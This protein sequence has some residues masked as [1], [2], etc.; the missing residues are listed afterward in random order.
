MGIEE[1]A[2]NATTAPVAENQEESE[3]PEAEESDIEKPETEKPETE[4]PETEKP[5]S[6]TWVHRKN[7]QS[8]NTRIGYDAMARNPTFA[9]AEQ[10]GG[11]WEVKQLTDHFHP[12]VAL[13]ATT[14]MEG[15]GIE[16][17]G[18]PLQDFTLSRF[19][20][21]FVFRNPKLISTKKA[22]GPAQ[23]R[24]L[25]KRNIYKPQGV[26]AMAVDG[27]EFLKQPKSSIPVDELYLYQYFQRR[28]SKK[29]IAKAAEEEEIDSDLESVVSEDFEKYLAENTDL[30]FASVVKK[31]KSKAEKIKKKRGN[32]E[33][34]DD[35]DNDSETDLDAAE[36][37]SADDYD[38]DKDFQEA[39][40]DFDEMLN[41]KSIPDLAAGGDVEDM[42]DE[43]DEMDGDDDEDDDD[44]DDEGSDDDDDDEFSDEENDED[45]LGFREEDVDFSDDEEKEEKEGKGG[46]GGK[47]V[48]KTA[49]KSK[50]S[51]KS[52][53]PMEDDMDDLD[54]ALDAGKASKKKRS[55]T[56]FADTA[57]DFI[58]AEEFSAMLESNSGASMKFA[59]TSEAMANKDKASAKQLAWE[60]SRDRWMTDKNRPRNG[61]RQNKKG[62]PKGGQ[63]GGRKSNSGPAFRKN[64]A[65]RGGK[66]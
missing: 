52:K 18:D 39:F 50:L 65:N 26:R 66:K 43:D 35:D 16:Y 62:G 12:S 4:K 28:S 53:R 31:P 38:Q 59:G 47:V 58:G 54:W 30:D 13:F 19:L 37:D 61:A 8:K 36:C 63:K 60:S 48:K 9:R 57:S 22:D 15:S 17:S 5:Q 29:G 33:E 64:R 34:E 32:D 3:K 27:K 56:M 49:L 10:S 55:R 6:S 14:V 2:E 42:D 44:D 41:D 7:I 51:I 23:R 21:R 46:K 1:D 25:G 24:V 11:F 40:K 20:D 45:G